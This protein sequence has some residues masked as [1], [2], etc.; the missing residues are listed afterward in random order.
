MQHKKVSEEELDYIESGGGVFNRKIK[1]EESKKFE[2]ENLAIVLSHK[3]L[4]GIYL[5]Q[6]CLGGTLLFFLHGFQ[7]I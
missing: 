3:K 1:G 5:G 6:F 4:W 2:W 7:N